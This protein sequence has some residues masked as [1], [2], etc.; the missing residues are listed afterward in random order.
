[1]QPRIPVAILVRVSTSKQE[2]ARQIS[3][4]EAVAEVNSWEVVET[5]QET[6]SGNANLE[7]RPALRRIVQL[8]DTGKIKKLLVHE[9]SRLS[10]RPSVALT[11]VEV[12][13]GLKVSVYWLA[14]NVETLLPSGKRN[15]SAA[16]ML[17]LLAE[18]AKAERETLRE[19]IL[20]GL[21]EA[22]RKG[23]KLG[24]PIGS[25]MNREAY[26]QKHQRIVRLLRQGMS[27]RNSASIATVDKATVCRVKKMMDAQA[28]PVRGIPHG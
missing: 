23:I 7:D 4:L 17:A 21:E 1:M 27:I 6:V 8:G 18:M 3:E 14:Q 28:H 20:S 25:S 13:E 12:L 10:R 19:R 2:V 5:L 26:L 16:I 22:K 9:V 11:F 15:P 24:R